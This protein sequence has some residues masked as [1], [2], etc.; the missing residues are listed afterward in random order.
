MLAE[1][2][3][4]DTIFRSYA[5][6]VPLD[7]GG[8]GSGRSTISRAGRRA[9]PVRAA[10]VSSSF[11]L[12]APVE[13][14]REAQATSRAAGRRLGIVGGEAAAL[15]FAFAL[16]AAMTLR[17]DLAAARRRLAW[18]GARGWQLA[19]LTVAESTRA[20]AGRHAIG[21]A[22]AAR[23]SSAIAAE[24]AGSPVGDVLAR[25][26]LSRQGLGLAAARRSGRHRDPRRRRTLRSA[27][28]ALRPARVRPRSP[29]SRSSRSSSRAAAARAISRSSCPP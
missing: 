18:Y 11:D 10:G 9:R 4:L 20:R 28:D 23:S 24:R 3:S 7:P 15:L 12:V 22:L 6:V 2:A 25:S 26:V 13:E 29:R 16:L 17:T 14:L 5:W 27:G 1:V 8:R 21:L 19:L